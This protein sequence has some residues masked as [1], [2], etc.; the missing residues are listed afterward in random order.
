MA[1]PPVWSTASTASVAGQ[2]K[3]LG[4]RGVLLKM[5]ENGQIVQLKCE[6]PTCYCPKGRRQFQQRLPGIPLPE[7]APNAD[8]YPTLKRDKG[9]LVPW[10]VR[11]SHLR[12][13]NQDFAWRGRI[14]R[15]LEKDPSM[16]FKKI[17]SALN[18]KGIEPPPGTSAWSARA[19]RKAYVS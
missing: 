11:L 5:A 16:S 14:R 18:E 1:K 2:L 9:H 8:H 3:D 7:W 12:C 4:V 10:N 6:M 19:A 13:N 17:A 15:M